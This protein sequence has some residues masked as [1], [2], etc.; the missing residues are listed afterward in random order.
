[1][2]ISM[3]AGWPSLPVTS[4]GGMSLAT[5]PTRSAPR[6]CTWRIS[7][8]LESAA[9]A[10]GAGGSIANASNAPITHIRHGLAF[11]RISP[12]SL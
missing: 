7:A 11:M 6:S 10:D 5:S 3:P 2:A 4:S 1:M 9:V 12:T 8:K